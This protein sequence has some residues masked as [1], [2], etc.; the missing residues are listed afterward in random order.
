MSVFIGHTT[1]DGLKC[2]CP[3]E[4]AQHTLPKCYNSLERLICLLRAFMASVCM[5]TLARVKGQTLHCHSASKS[6]ILIFVLIFIQDKI[7][8]TCVFSTLSLSSS[9]RLISR[10]KAVMCCFICLLYEWSQCGSQSSHSSQEMILVAVTINFSWPRFV[11]VTI[12]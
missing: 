8:L 9:G 5:F 1:R 6:I 12:S 10:T 2:Y 4:E 11:V 7:Y 3:Q